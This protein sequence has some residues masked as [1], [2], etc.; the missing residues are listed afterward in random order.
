MDKTYSLEID[1]S[2]LVDMKPN[3]IDL[4]TG[5]RKCFQ[6]FDRSTNFDPSPDYST[7]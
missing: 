1:D 4:K 7:F 5:D 3:L 2:F 6:L